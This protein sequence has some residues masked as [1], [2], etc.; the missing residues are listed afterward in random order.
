VILRCTKKLLEV[1]RAG[2]VAE[3]APD[4]GD[5]Y[6]SLLWF[7]RRKCLLVT[8][9]GTLFSV[10]EPGVRAA[11]L[12]D[13]HRLITGLIERELRREG[14]PPGTFGNLRGHDLVLAKTADRSVLGCMNDMAF[15]CEVAITGSGG[16]AHCDP[17]EL[18][19]ALHRN[20]NS[21]RGYRPPVELATEWVQR[22]DG[23]H[24]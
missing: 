4:V 2:R 24:Q 20:I 10:F 7:D 17:G 15:L 8:R 13:T 16:L 11:R 21:P 14:L 9:A 19:Q 22:R 23:S 18:N 1:L 6:A 5:W 3:P 12:R